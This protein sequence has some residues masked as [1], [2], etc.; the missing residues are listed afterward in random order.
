MS[1]DPD[2]DDPDDDDARGD[3]FDSF[4]EYRDRD[5]DPFDSFGDDSSGSR[6]AAPGS[7]DGETGDADESATRDSAD[8]SAASAS[9]DAVDPDPFE[10]MG[11][12]GGGSQPVDGGDGDDGTDER[13]GDPLADVTVSDEDP[14]ESSASAFERS[15]VEGIDPDEVWE[16]LTAEPDAGDGDRDAVDAPSEGEE[17]DVVTVSKHS[18]CE[19]CEYF[20][21]PPDVAC[22]HEGTDILAFVDVDSVRVSNCPVVEERRE[23]E[24]DA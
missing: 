2:T 24:E 23:L 9:T 15:G 22:G 8:E 1:G 14:F 21:E 4:D 3:P 19:G 20:S 5:G 13:R 6:G 17:D 11:D 16:R 12:R 10:Y 18:Y 7:D